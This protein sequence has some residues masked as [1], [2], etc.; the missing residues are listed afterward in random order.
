M[1]YRS[2]TDII[3]MILQAATT[4]ATKT[5]I[6]YSAYLS[7]AQVKE[8]LGFLLQ[9]DLIRYEEGSS[10]YKLSVRGMKVLEAYEGISEMISLDGQKQVNNTPFSFA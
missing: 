8:Y 6:M 3:A 2:R 7:Y 10:L 4:G 5:R 9:R 1:K